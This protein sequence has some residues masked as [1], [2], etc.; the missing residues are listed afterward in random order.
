MKRGKPKEI[1]ETKREREDR[2][3]Q[4]EG[5]RRFRAS[6][7]SACGNIKDPKKSRRDWKNKS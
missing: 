5:G 4:T 6:T 7:W 2:M 1:R 3:E